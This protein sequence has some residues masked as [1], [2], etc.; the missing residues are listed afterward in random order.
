M[1]WSYADWYKQNSQ[2]LSAKRKKRYQED[3]AYREQ[4]LQRSANRRASLKANTKP[5]SSVKDVCEAIGITAWT[6]NRWKLN[7]YIPVGNLRS[8]RFSDQQI[9][10]LKLLRGFFEKYPR[11]QAGLHQDELSNIVSVVAHNW[12]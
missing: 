7:G 12:S 4:V 3:P 10:L 8:Y 2:A 11:R 6:L 9:E 1:S 5:G